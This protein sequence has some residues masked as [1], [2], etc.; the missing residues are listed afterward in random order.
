VEKINKQTLGKQ[1]KKAKKKKKKSTGS[2]KSGTQKGL[3]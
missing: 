3:S 2:S 1:K